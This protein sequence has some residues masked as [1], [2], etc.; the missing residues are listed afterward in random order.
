MCVAIAQP[1]N[2]ETLTIEELSKGWATNPDG[3]GYA[4]IDHNGKIQTVFSMD[5][6]SFILQYIESHTTYGATSPFIV[7]MRIATHG[8]VNINNCHPFEIELDGDGEMW[9]MHN[10]IIDAME[11]DIKGTDYTDTQGLA[12]HVLSELH[13]GWLD[14]KHIVSF[15]EDFIDYSKLVFLTTS[16]ALS[17][18]LYIVNE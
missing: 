16:P 18:Q 8:S 10:G 6:D 4:Y 9:F 11:E 17:S 2:T 3:G 12:I 5:E 1:T 13:D 14:N 7:H 15:V